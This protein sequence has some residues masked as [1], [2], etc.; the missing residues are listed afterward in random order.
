M[1]QGT[2]KKAAPKSTR[3]NIDLPTTTVWALDKMAADGR[4]KTKPYIELVLIEF[5]K[6]NKSKKP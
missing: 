2:V 5:V 4:M 6:N 3:K 1:K